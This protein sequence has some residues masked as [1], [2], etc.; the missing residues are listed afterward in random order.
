MTT[1][2]RGFAS[3]SNFVRDLGELIFQAAS[4]EVGPFAASVRGAAPEDDA[5]TLFR[6]A[7]V[8]GFG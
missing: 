2:F 5:V 7:G 1:V 3:E 8:P 6:P 4:V